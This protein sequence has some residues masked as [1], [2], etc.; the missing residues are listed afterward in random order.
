M[1]WPGLPRDKGAWRQPAG[2]PPPPL[3]RRGPAGQAGDPR[4]CMA[5][6]VIPQAQ[7]P[8]SR[9]SAGAGA[10]FRGGHHISEVL[11]E[12]QEAMGLTQQGE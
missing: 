3:Q 9:L 5:P 12:S 4:P 10:V 11:P 7:R 1:G 2:E 6:G 8:P